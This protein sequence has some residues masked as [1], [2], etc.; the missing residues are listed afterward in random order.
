MRCAPLLT[1][2]AAVSVFAPVALGQMGP[3]PVVVAPVER[4]TVPITRELVATVLPVTRSTLA[5]ERDGLVAERLFDE[6]QKVD[7]GAVLVRLQ[8]DELKVLLDAANVAVLGDFPWALAPA[9]AIFV[10]VLAVNLIVQAPLP[11]APVSRS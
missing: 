4:S 8:T 11:A 10:V 2:L 9:A 1:I 3:A 6:G 5:S 7:Q